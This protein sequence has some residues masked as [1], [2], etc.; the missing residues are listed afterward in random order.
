MQ[1]TR[2]AILATRSS[3]RE[4]MATRQHLRRVGCD[5]QPELERLGRALSLAVEIRGCRRLSP[6]PDTPR[7]Q[8]LDPTTN[9]DLHDSDH[10]GLALSLGE[11]V[12]SR[13]ATP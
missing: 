11:K 13:G 7:A 5:N 4:Y 2:P 12:S 8:R 1:V 10:P 9:G 6:S 3:E